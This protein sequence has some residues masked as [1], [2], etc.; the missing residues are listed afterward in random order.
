MDFVK[1]LEEKKQRETVW[2]RNGGS[3]KE[4]LYLE[5]FG[6][7]NDYILR[8]EVSLVMTSPKLA[9]PDALFGVCFM[10]ALY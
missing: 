1:R 7:S 4:I 6:A 8:K 5:S 10:L 2:V 3:L 9:K